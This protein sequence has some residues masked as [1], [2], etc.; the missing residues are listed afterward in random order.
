MAAAVLPLVRH[1]T[2]FEV[3]ERYRVD[4]RTIRRWWKLGRFPKPIKCQR[5]MRWSLHVLE[6]WEREQACAR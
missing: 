4:E 6:E 1:L 3:A 2:S 5:L